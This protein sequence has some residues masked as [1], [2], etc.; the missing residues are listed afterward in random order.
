M[1]KGLFIVLLFSISMQSVGQKHKKL[2][3]QGNRDYKESV[4]EESEL[5]YR[6]SIDVNPLYN[7]AT[8]NLGNALYKQEKY[9]DAVESFSQLTENEIDSRDRAGS[10]YNLGNTLL[11]SNKPAESIDAYKNALRLNPDN[12]EAKYNLAY[13][14]DLLQQQEENKEQQKDQDNSNK[15]E[16]KDQQQE[17][18]QKEKQKSENSDDQKQGS[19]QEPQQQQ[20][21]KED[22]ERLLQ[23]IAGDEEKVQEKVKKAKA[24]KQRVKTLKNW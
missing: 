8:F 4:F 3:R 6:K 16:N 21:T 19:K 23:A 15:Q 14:Q 18:N 10:F 22:A 1:Y 2:L 17:N 24:A 7:D 11:K 9:E 20:M 12:M 5:Q 13:A